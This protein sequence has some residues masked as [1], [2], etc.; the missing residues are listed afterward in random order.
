MSQEVTTPDDEMS[1]VEKLDVLIDEIGDEE[2]DPDGGLPPIELQT[3]ILFPV[4]PEAKQFAAVI[5][6]IHPRSITRHK[7]GEQHIVRITIGL[8]AQQI[9]DMYLA[10]SGGVQTPGPKRPPAPT[11]PGI[12]LPPGVN[13]SGG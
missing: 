11:R 2:A 13:V 9:K 1:G 5:H 12:Q 3:A 6:S 10:S 4:N 7:D 8:T